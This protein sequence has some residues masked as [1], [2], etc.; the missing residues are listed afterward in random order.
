M[1]RIYSVTISGRTFQSYDLKE[2]LARA[3][4]VK[5]NMRQAGMT[6]SKQLRRFQT[7]EPS[8]SFS[9]TEMAAVH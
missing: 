1:N 6:A 4:S 8:N 3:V 5:K 2:L 9:G 7:E